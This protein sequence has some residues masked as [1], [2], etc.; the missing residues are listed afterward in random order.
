MEAENYREKAPPIMRKY[1]SPEAARAALAQVN[2]YWDE[3]LSSVKVE[4]PDP[5][6]N[7]MLN[8]WGKRQSWVTFN[9]N[10]NAGYYHGGLL[11]GAVSYTHLGE[12]AEARAAGNQIFNCG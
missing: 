9:A 12:A 10:R 11:F 6:M 5:E 4:T 2:A 7:K 8:V 1:R 3:Y